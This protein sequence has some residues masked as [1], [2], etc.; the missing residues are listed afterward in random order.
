MIKITI[1]KTK[2]MDEEEKNRYISY[3]MNSLDKQFGRYGEE[4]KPTINVPT[5]MV[6]QI[7]ETEITEEQFKAVQKAIIETL[8]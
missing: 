6:A 3:Q 1:V 5:E 2:E 8:I 4:R 7:L